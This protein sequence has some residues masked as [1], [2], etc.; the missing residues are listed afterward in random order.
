MFSRAQSTN[1]SK[2]PQEKNLEFLNECMDD[3]AAE[4]HKASGHA[5]A[6]VRQQQQQA[7]WVQK[8]RSENAARRAAGQ[9]V[10]PEEEPGNPL[11]RP[12]PEPSRLDGCL[13][14]NQVNQYAGQVDAF[15][16]RALT[17]L[18]TLQALCASQA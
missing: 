1:P 5:R 2:P 9:E 14:L 8:R 3:L 7:Q 12:L 17:K 15:A 6:V 11:F 10:L 16:A 4:G 18:R 13:I